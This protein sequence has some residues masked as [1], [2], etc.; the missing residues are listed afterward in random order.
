FKDLNVAIDGVQISDGIEILHA[1][2]AIHGIDVLDQSA[3]R[4]VNGIFHG[5]FHTL[6][7][8]VAGG[9]GEGVGARF[10]VNGNEIEIG[11]LAGRGFY[12]ADFDFVFVPTL[13]AHSAVDV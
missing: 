6:F 3:A 12:R 7:L 4:D 2:G 10:D 11:F 8:R 5:H 13:D 1:Q 9:N